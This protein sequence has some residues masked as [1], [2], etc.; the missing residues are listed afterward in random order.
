MLFKGRSQRS[1]DPKGRVML[2]P[3]FREILL[4]RCSEGRLVLTTYDDCIVGYPLPDWEEF[5]EKF[6]RIKSPSKLV[7]HF[8]R[9]VIGG[10]REVTIDKQGRIPL[11]PD[12]REYAGIDGKEIVLVGQG[13]K[14]EIWNHASIEDVLDM[15]F[16][17]VAEELAANGIE[18]DI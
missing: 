14:F 6:N 10:A 17:D 8:R 12:H 9:L 5:E 3:E 7:R 11:S 15:N 4:A 16:D 2:P 13:S 18:L 1:L